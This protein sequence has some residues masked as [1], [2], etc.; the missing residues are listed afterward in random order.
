MEKITSKLVF[1]YQE[2]DKIGNWIS[3]V[4]YIDGELKALEERTIEYY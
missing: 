3:R 4:I 2:Y 1:D